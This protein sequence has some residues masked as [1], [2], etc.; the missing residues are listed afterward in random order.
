[1]NSLAHLPLSPPRIG[2]PGETDADVLGIAETIEWLQRECRSGRWHLA[3][4]VRQRH[5]PV[6]WAGACVLGLS[7]A[8]ALAS[9]LARG[10]A[11][12][13]P[14]GR[15]CLTS[16]AVN[17]GMCR[18]PSPTSPPSHTPHFSGSEC[19][20]GATPVLCPLCLPCVAAPLPPIFGAAPC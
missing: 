17:A 9:L 12:S 19:G 18:S 13:Q 2:L 10:L 1:M 14:H 4:N 20:W 15:E 3:L 11:Y 6:P 7:L 5:V 8:A 16:T